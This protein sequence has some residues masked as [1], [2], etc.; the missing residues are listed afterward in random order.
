M[1]KDALIL[2][3]LASGAGAGAIQG[4]GQGQGQGQLQ[5]QPNGSANIRTRAVSATVSFVFYKTAPYEFEGSRTEGVYTQVKGLMDDK[6]AQDVL[7]RYVNPHG[8]QQPFAP[9]AALF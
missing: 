5:L 6:V 4:Q 7:D 9:I 1:E 8:Q 3:T 2:H